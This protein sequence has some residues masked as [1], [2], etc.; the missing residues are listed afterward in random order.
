MAA[1]AGTIAEIV[2]V[3]SVVLMTLITYTNIHC[4]EFVQVTMLHTHF[5]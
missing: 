5:S 4:C 1:A 3:L 2:L